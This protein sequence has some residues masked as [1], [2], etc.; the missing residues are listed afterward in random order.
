MNHLSPLG[1][2]H[3]TA[4]RNVQLARGRLVFPQGDAYGFGVSNVRPDDVN[5]TKTCFQAFTGHLL[6]EGRTVYT[7]LS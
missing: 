3:L 4:K 2:L 6:S 1:L 7:L 5:S